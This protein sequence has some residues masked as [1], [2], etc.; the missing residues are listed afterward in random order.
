M[1]L[2]LEADYNF[3]VRL[4]NLMQYSW[5]LHKNNIKTHTDFYKNKTIY[6]EGQIPR[7]NINIENLLTYQIS[8]SADVA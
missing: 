7:E 1:T 2:F 4:N 8:L 5:L 6:N 3:F